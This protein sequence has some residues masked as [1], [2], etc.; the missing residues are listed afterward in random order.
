MSTVAYDNTKY[1]A[2]EW[3]KVFPSAVCSGICGD[4]A[5]QQR[6]GYHIGRKFQ[7]KS[8]YSVTRSDDKG[9]PGDASSAIDMSMN[10]RDMIECT[11]RLR[12]VWLDKSDPR[13]K[14]LNAFN[15][16]LG[17]GTAV[18]FDMV[19]GRKSTASPDH[20][21][22]VHYEGRRKWVLSRVA[23]DA[24]LSVLRNESKVNY[25]HRNGIVVTQPTKAPAGKQGAKPT[26]PKYPGAPL[27]VGSKGTAVRQYQ[28]R[29]I[30]RGYKSIG[31]A[32]G[33]FGPKSRSTTMTF[34]RVCKIKADG[35]VGPVTW[36]LPWTR[37]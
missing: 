32:D 36:P 18:R 2:R 7:P 23:A 21:W 5:H 11:L 34:Q 33:N 9:G 28:E 16:W 20:K 35:E 1:L 4:R 31:K 14:Y 8:N 17:Y 26:A 10:R 13:R 37:P 24:V 30:A 3:E 6:G 19:S 12:R 22:H 29:M 25:L 15:G 27:K